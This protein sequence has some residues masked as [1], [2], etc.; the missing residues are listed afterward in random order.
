[1][2]RRFMPILNMTQNFTEFPLM[3][4]FMLMVGNSGFLISAA[5]QHGLHIF[6]HYELYNG[7]GLTPLFIY[8][9]IPL[10]TLLLIPGIEAVRT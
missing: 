5:E 4:A 3:F 1:M 9:A 2:R 8:F 10:G 6:D 7:D